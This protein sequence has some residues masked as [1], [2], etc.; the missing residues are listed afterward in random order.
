MPVEYFHVVFTL[1]HELAPLALQNQAL[2]Y[3]FLFRAA[4]ETLR[5]IAADPKRLGAQLGVVAVLHTWGQTLQHHPHVHCVVS[6][7]GLAVDANG[8][9]LEPARWVSC[10]PGFLL[11]QDVLKAKYKGKFLAWLKAAYAAGQLQFHGKLAAL[12]EP[13]AFRA[14][15]EPLYVKKWWVYAKRPFAC[16]S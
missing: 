5:E 14:L 6:G 8:R 7:G 16:S 9:V 10:P 11:P 3:D 13:A 2:L 4:A 15:L 1:P 12:A